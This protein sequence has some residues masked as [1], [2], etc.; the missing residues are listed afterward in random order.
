MRPTLLQVSTLGRLSHP[1][2]GQATDQALELTAAKRRIREL[3]TELAVSRKTNEIFCD[4]DLVPKASS[5]R[6]TL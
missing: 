3:E 6:S 5:R 1:G 2:F 4:Q